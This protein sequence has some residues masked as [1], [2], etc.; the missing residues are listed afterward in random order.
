MTY[1]YR[2]KRLAELVREFRN[3]EGLT[4]RDLQQLTGLSPATLSRI[5]NAETK[6]GPDTP[7]LLALMDVCGIPLDEIIQSDDD[8]GTAQLHEISTQ[9]RASRELSPATLQALEA[10]IRAVRTQNEDV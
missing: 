4:L 10:V 7:N 3:R 9:L 8:A 1:I 5:E 6:A 2:R